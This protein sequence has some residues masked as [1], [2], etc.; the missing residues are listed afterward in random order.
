MINKMFKRAELEDKKN[1]TLKEKI[2][3]WYLESEVVDFVLDWTYYPYRKLVERTKRF[4]FWGW[5]MKD[6]HDWDGQFVYDVLCLKLERMEKCFKEDGN[7]VW[8]QSPEEPE[9]KSMKL[10][11]EAITIGKRLR[12]MDTR[13]YLPEL[14][15]AHDEKWGE[16]KM[17]TA[18]IED[19]TSVRC[20][21]GRSKV[22][23]DEDKE[24]EREEQMAI[25]KKQEKMHT[26]DKQRFFK[27][28]RDNLSS[29]W[30]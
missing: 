23:T 5:K 13:D 9:Y 30:D 17:N 20:I 18:P 19:S 28:L 22:V 26:R 8:N 27:L 2:H 4:F 16:L 1:P 21:I 14:T 3:L 25:W 11:E 6:N 10:L 15:K 12:D 7:C 24:K 29:W